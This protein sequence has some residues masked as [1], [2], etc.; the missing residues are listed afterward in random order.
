[1]RPRL[2]HARSGAGLAEA[3]VQGAY[4]NKTTGK[5]DRSKS[6]LVGAN[7]EINANTK[8]ELLE[9]I[10][11]LVE[12]VGQGEVVQ[13]TVTADTQYQQD[14][15]SLVKAAMEDRTHEAGG[16]MYIMGETLGDAVWET[17]GRLGFT[18]KFLLR[19]DVPRGQEGRIRVRQ[20]NVV[21]WIITRESF[22][23][24]SIVRQN[25]VYPE[26]VTLA[27]YTTIDDTERA[28]APVELMDEKYT[29]MLE[30]TMVRE[31][32]LVRWLATQAAP[33]FNDVF[34]F[35]ELTPAIY[36]AMQI[37]IQRWGLSAP[38]CLIAIDL[39]NDIRTN[40]DFLSVYEPVSKLTLIEEGRLGK[41]YDT[42]IYTDGLRYESLQVLEEGE[43][44]FFAE[45]QGLGGFCEYMPLQTKPADLHHVGIGAE[46]WYSH[47]SRGYSVTNSRG[48]V[49]GFRSS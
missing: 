8:T 19:H 35:A 5:M 26:V 40:S 23:P 34:T 46:G 30:A 36:S 4:L 37:Q 48:V 33:V 16:G 20:K 49:W 47:M 13:S 15:D 1:M 18:S 12:L 10:A 28:M 25:W 2:I 17:T 42:E 38:H 31:D 21:S 29:E 27:T 14:C 9:R 3:G 39:W 41:I 44:F 45:P 43:M 32:N 24:R 7:G 11:G 22:I 6:P